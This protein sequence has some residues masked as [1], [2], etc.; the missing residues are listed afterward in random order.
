ME[1]V[2]EPYTS[3][4]L[5]YEA[6][7]TVGAEIYNTKINIKSHNHMTYISTSK[8]LLNNHI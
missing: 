6:N 7:G 5:P 3:Y 4:F 8:K 2:S 1:L